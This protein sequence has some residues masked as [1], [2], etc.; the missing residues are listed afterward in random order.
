MNSEIFNGW[1]GWLTQHSGP[2]LPLLSTGVALLAL[3]LLWAMVR[4]SWRRGRAARNYDA[5]ADRFGQ[6]PAITERQVEL[7]RYLQQAF[8]DGVVLYRPRLA[9]FLAVR[10]TRDR[11]AAQQRLLEQQVDFLVCADDGKPLFAFEVDAFK[12]PAAGGP[13]RD[14][15]EK[16]RMLKSA[17][18]RLVRLKGALASLPPPEILRMRLLAAQRTPVPAAEPTASDFK[19]SGFASS[20]FAASGFAH[21]RSADSGVMSLSALMALPDGEDP[22]SGVRKR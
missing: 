10:R 4:R 20:G 17:G 13:D 22:W 12:D 9:S 5:S 3:M 6:T 18:V 11:L 1:P 19:A 14:A 16:N 7:L 2:W 15:S 8:G 21:S